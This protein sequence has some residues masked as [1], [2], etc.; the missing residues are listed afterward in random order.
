MF[1]VSIIDNFS[2]AHKLRGY[3]GRCEDLHGHNWKIIV[4]VTAQK[5]DNIGLAVDF[6]LLKRKL[7]KVLEGLDHKYLNDLAYFKKFNPSSENIAEYLYG[8]LAAA[9]NNRRL[10][11]KEVKV[12]ESDNSAAAFY[13]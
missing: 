13:K 2:A 6:R 5:L 8:K 7:N 12:W 1:E 10:K 3:R 9:I 4:T 11:L